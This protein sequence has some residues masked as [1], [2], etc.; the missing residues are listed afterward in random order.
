VDG[1]LDATT[2][3]L[4]F[5]SSFATNDRQLGAS[6]TGAVALGEMALYDHEVPAAEV[7]QHRQAGIGALTAVKEIAS[8]TYDGSGDRLTQ[9]VGGVTT[10]YVWDKVGGLPQLVLERRNGVQTRRY[11]HGEAPLSM[12]DSSGTDWYHTDA[13]GSVTALTNSTGTPQWRYSYEA[14][15]SL[16]SAQKLSA[17]APANEPALHRPAARPGHGSLLPAGPLL[18]PEPGPVPGH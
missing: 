4:P 18:R 8:Y 11:V 5:L 17:S 3:G 9:T 13:L 14:F 16:R 6:T 10:S 2:S 1:A 15:G 7:S 12:T